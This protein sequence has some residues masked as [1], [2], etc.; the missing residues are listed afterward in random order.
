MPH[1][2]DLHASRPTKTNGKSAV[3]TTGFDSI[4]AGGGVTANGETDGGDI[5]PPG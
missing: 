2:L 4:G 3:G 1:G 5:V